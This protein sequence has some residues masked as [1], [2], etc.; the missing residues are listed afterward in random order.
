MAAGSASSTSAKS[1]S[2]T[3]PSAASRPQRAERRLVSQVAMVGTEQRGSSEKS[4][5]CPGGG[6]SCAPSGLLQR[7]HGRRSRSSSVRSSRSSFTS[8][9]SAVSDPCSRCSRQASDRARAAT[10]GVSTDFL[11]ES[12]VAARLGEVLRLHRLQRQL[13]ERGLLFQ[14][15]HVT[16][17]DDVWRVVVDGIVVEFDGLE[18]E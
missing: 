5:E 12:R 14:V 9:P 15:R 1:A 13:L 16:G 17:R 4:S 2:S 8:T 3:A 7:P 10:A 11:E 6:S 18:S